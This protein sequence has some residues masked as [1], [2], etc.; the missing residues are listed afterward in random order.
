MTTRVGALL[1]LLAA[2]PLSAQIC[3]P[4]VASNWSVYASPAPATEGM[5][6][7]LQANASFGCPSNYPY[8]CDPIPYGFQSCDIL[9]W[10]FGDGTTATVTGSGSVSHVYAHWGLFD[11]NLHIASTRGSTDVLGTVYVASAPG[12]AIN[13]VPY[14][15]ANE[16]DGSVTAHLTRSGDLSRTNRVGWRVD[17]ERYAASVIAPASGAITFLPGE[18]EH[19]LVFP[20]TRDHLYEGEYIS[21]LYWNLTADGAVAGT[22]S[23]GA[24]D[25]LHMQ[26]TIRTADAEPKPYGA[27]RGI[28]VSKGSPV[29]H[30]PIDLSGA[31]ASPM[32]WVVFWHEIDDSAVDGVDYVGSHPW[33]AYDLPP[34]TLHPFLEIPLIDNPQPGT[35]SFDVDVYASAFPLTRS[36]ATVTIA[37]DS[38]HLTADRTSVILVVGSDAKVSVSSSAPLIE[39]VTATAVSSDPTVF[40]VDL[41]AVIPV[42]GSATIVIHAVKP[43]RATLTVTPAG[44]APATVDVQVMQVR[45]RAAVH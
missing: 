36:R 22:G 40:T 3:A 30:V 4:Q 37:D 13:T 18:S 12:T 33:G 10:T 28:V 25:A 38:F 14:F 6:V 26:S 32:R 2:T 41:P 5:P 27:L 21:F 24:I 20:I 43:G 45:R 35:R 7:T 29:V 1:V 16:L 34:G 31:F 9:Q 17:G 23:V 8:A 44:G 39:P 42:E 11:V 15:Y 19:T